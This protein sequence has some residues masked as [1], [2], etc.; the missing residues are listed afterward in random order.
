LAGL[1]KLESLYLW[2]NQISNLAAL[3]NK[4]VLSRLLLHENRISDITPLLGL[5]QLQELRLFNQAN[6][7]GLD[8]SQ[9]QAIVAALATTDVGVDGFW[10]DPD[11]DP[12]EGNIDCFP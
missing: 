10:N 2:G 7:P 3:Q 11:D 4:T 1:V 9:Q 8:C 6:P 12:D 5:T